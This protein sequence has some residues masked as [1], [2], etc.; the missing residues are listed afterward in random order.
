MQKALALESDAGKLARLHYLGGQLATERNQVAEAARAFALSLE[1]DPSQG[2]THLA[3]GLALKRLL[4][5]DE[6]YLA[7]RTAVDLMPGDPT[8]CYQL[9]L[10]LYRRGEP[11]AAADQLR[12]AHE[13]R[14]G[15]RSILYNLTRALHRSG[16]RSEF[17]SYREKLAGMQLASARARE[18]ELATARLHA[19]AVELEEAG[20]YSEALARYREVL[21]VEPFHAVARRNLAL[22]LCRLGRWDEGIRELRDL[23]RENPDNTEARRSLAIVLDQA[24]A[25]AYAGQEAHAEADEGN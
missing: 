11:Q 19:E 7:L 13:L 6:A 24:E 10:E 2:E 9:G 20:N 1:L 21:E 17:L 18:A 12:R 22:A 25:A 3:L 15:D 8:A 5:E 14:P 4:R 16:R 23:V